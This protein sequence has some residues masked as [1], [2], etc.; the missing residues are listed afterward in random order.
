M[1]SP[2]AANGVSQEKE[3]LFLHAQT[4]LHPGSGAALGTVDLPVQRERHTQWPTIASS[5]LKGVLR[6][7]IRGRI[8]ERA[9]LN[10]LP[11]WDDEP[12]KRASRSG[13]RR[14][15]ADATLEL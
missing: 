4:A 9:D 5:A 7:A 6:D 8:A 1:S 3:L 10:D 13:R 14:E 11:R 12:Q 15:D 2:K